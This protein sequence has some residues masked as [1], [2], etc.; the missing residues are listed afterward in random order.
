MTSVGISESD[1]VLVAGATGGVGQLAVAKLLEM[2]SKVR[3]LTR[4][5]AKAEKMFGEKVSV[6]VGDI[7]DCAT[8]GAATENVTHII[9]ASGTTVFP[10]AR[11]EFDENPSPFEWV[12]LFLDPQYSKAKAKNNPEQ[13]DAKGVANLVAAAP[14][15][16]KRF[17]FISSIGVLRK[18]AFPYSLLNRFGGLDAK[19]KAEETIINSG[20][21]YTIIRP[22]RLIDGPYTSYDLNSLIK[23]TT[24]GKLDVI[25]GTGDKLA[26]DTSRID[27]AGA[28]VESIKNTATVGKIFEIINKGT[29]PAAIDWNKLFSSLI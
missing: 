10:S 20:L 23:A 21:P 11:W 6:A 17:V 1:L 26:G 16:L 7:R 12:K 3:V 5:A 25:I 2:G 19:L 13:A 4:N 8:L 24:E 27:V 22:G 18:D 15:D 28:C 14:K 9:C 29:R